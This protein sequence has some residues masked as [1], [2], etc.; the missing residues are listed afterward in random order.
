M[1]VCY[2]TALAAEARASAESGAGSNP[3]FAAGQRQVPQA[4]W[5]RRE[6]LGLL[7]I[8]PPD[9][10]CS[11]VRVPNGAASAYLKR[12]DVPTELKPILKQRQVG[13]VGSGTLGFDLG[14]DRCQFATLHSIGHRNL[15]SFHTA[16]CAHSWNASAAGDP[17]QVRACA[18]CGWKAAD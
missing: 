15:K 16:D 13:D 2:S 8:F 1:R 4:V 7:R 3:R 18:G 5:P 10:P 9:T 14:D 12:L 17:F 11:P 6:T